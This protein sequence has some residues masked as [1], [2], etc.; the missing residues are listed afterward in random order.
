MLPF[1]I[2]A[3]TS[4]TSTILVGLFDSFQ[5]LLIINLGLL[6][7]GNK[8]SIVSIS[9]GVGLRLEKG[10]EVPETALDVAVSLHFFKAH[11]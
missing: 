9:G 7:V 2:I 6:G 8:E 4:K 5:V 1:T 10:I 11:F 3:Q